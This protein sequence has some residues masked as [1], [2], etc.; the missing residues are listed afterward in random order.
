MVVGLGNP[1]PDYDGT[2][3][4]VGRLCVEAFARKA[5]IAIDRRR[6]RSRVGSGPALGRR[7]WLLEPQTYMNLSGRAVREACRDLALAPSEVWVVYDEL[8]LPFCRLRIRVGG[9]AAGHNG[10]R[11]IIEALGDDGFAR[12]R[13][14]VGKPPRPGGEAG[15]S[16]VLNRFSKVEVATLGA[17][18]DGVAS[19]LEDGARLGLEHAMNVY[20]RPG[21]LRC[22]EIP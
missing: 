4:N 6:W 15:R 12:F 8:D 7:L 3:H 2:R 18:V 5:G 19:A 14:G 20:N 13:V 9:S 17:V 11:S 21:S 22:E 10:V 16:Y 1:G